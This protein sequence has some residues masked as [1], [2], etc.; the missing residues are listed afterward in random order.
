MSQ[1]SE[2]N[3]KISENNSKSTVQQNAANS[4][5][6]AD[7]AQSDKSGWLLKWTNYLKGMNID[8]NSSQ[9]GSGND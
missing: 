1:S 3:N 5:A 7:P 9:S 6:A 4:S 2:K 8:Q